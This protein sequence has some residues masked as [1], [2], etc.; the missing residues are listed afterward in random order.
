MYDRA[1]Y[2]LC[3]TLKMRIRLFGLKRKNTKTTNNII[4][5][6]KMF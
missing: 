4:K 2:C 3:G 1:K 5:V 6:T